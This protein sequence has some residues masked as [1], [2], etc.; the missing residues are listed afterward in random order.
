MGLID[1]A[2]KM[3]QSEA[4]LR[5]SFTDDVIKSAQ[6]ILTPYLAESK[7][8]AEAFAAAVPADFNMAKVPKN[9]QGKLQDYA[10]KA[11]QEYADAAALAS[12]LSPTNPRYQEAISKM[13][14]IRQGFQNNLESLQALKVYR[15][16][17]LNNQGN[18]SKSVEDPLRI[19]ENEIMQGEFGDNVEINDQGIF[20]NGT[21]IN[22][23][24]NNATIDTQGSA[25]YDRLYTNTINGVK[26]SGSKFNR[27]RTTNAVNGEFSKLGDKGI[28]AFAYDGIFGDD[29]TGY[30]FIDGYIK[31]KGFEEGSDEYKKMY[32][33]LKKP[34]SSAAYKQD[35]IDHVVDTLEDVHNEKVAEYR[36]ADI[37]AT[38]GG[39]GFEK[40]EIYGAYR[41]K[42]E[43]D[44]M[45]QAISNNGGN[46]G[47]VV[48]F[49]NTKY[50]Y[51]A[52]TG[53]FYTSD[54]IGKKEN[55]MT[56]EDVRRDQ[57]IYGYYTGPDKGKKI[58]TPGDYEPFEDEDGNI[59]SG[60]LI[61]IEENQDGSMVVQDKNGKQ[62]TIEPDVDNTYSE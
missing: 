33:D 57:K 27:G 32:N 42:R 3:Y 11:K 7:L 50:I 13:N 28:T 2:A 14:N 43:I 38:R 54:D 23:L 39:A 18:L 36:A 53:R 17:A 59:I 49:D 12:R 48:G 37:K 41:T 60:D 62:F 56:R 40:P 16:T 6:D 21:S 9:L 31:S 55:P 25:A 15:E 61:I 5:G 51:D 47:F 8:K 1:I 19:I 26:S 24:K 10:I 30:S 29:E 34:G 20:V 46:S 4:K 44:A 58:L 45:N 52:Q 35:F 22:D